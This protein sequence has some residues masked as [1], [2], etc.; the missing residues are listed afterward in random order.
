MGHQAWLFRQTGQQ[1][2]VD[3][4]RVDGRKAQ[5]RQLGDPLQDPADQAAKPRR[6]RQVVAPAGQVDP[7]QHHLVVAGGD[8]V[9]GSAPRPRPAGIE[10]EFPR[11]KGMTQKVQ[12]WSQPFWIST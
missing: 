7:G 9:R 1:V 3:L 5:A 12:R 8:E 2:G 10:R 4:G 11:P 6:A